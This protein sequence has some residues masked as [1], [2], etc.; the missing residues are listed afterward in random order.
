MCEHFGAYLRSH[1]LSLSSSW[2]RSG[3]SILNFTRLKLSSVS[4]VVEAL[5]KR[6]DIYKRKI[7]SVLNCINAKEN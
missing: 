3:R 4:P 1:F 2:Y 5:I 6:R 7:K